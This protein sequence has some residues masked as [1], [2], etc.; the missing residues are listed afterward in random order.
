M[1]K[2]DQFEKAQTHYKESMRILEKAL[3]KNHPEIAEILN[4]SGL[5]KKKIGLYEDAAD[6]YTRALEIVETCFGA[7]H[8]KVGMYLNNLADCCI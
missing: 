7:Q 6:D 1:R 5:A 8:P 3:G 4:S 2:Q